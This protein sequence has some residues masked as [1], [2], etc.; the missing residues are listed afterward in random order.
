M[1][2]ASLPGSAA[3]STVAAAAPAVAPSRAA[4]TAP[5]RIGHGR[6]VRQALVGSTSIRPFISMCM[7]WQNHWQ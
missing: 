7:A 4:S 1:A 5:Q 3:T 6:H 2:A